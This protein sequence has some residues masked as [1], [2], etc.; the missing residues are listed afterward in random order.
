MW[1]RRSIRLIQ[2]TGSLCISQCFIHVA[3]G[4][5]RLHAELAVRPEW[6]S[7]KRQ[8]LKQFLVATSHQQAGEADA[9]S[10]NIVPRPWI[11]PGSPQ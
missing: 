4:R 1:H 11:G 9:R 7:L 6:K 3:F 2:A 8:H 10:T 5:Q